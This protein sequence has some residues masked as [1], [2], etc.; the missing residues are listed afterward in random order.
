MIKIEYN[1]NPLVPKHMN[2]K[3]GSYRELTIQDAKS[4]DNIDHAISFWYQCINPITRLTEL[5]DLIMQKYNISSQE[6]LRDILLL[7]ESREE[8][9]RIEDN[10]KNQKQLYQLY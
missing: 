6:V 4:F 1:A 3:I 5:E 10:I 7:C 9:T 2:H 8:D